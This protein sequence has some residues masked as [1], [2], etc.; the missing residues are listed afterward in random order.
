MKYILKKKSRKVYDVFGINYSKNVIHFFVNLLYGIDM[1]Y[2]PNKAGRRYI[3][4][5]NNA[6][7]DEELLLELEEVRNDKD[8][9]WYFI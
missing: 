5:N 6:I 9:N 8:V 1:D 2:R 7:T 3:M 4:E